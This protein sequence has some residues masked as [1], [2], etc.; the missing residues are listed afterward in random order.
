MGLCSETDEQ[1]RNNELNK[2]L[3][4]LYDEES[5]EIKLLL[6]GAGGSGKTTIFKQMKIIHAS[7]FTDKERLDYKHS[8]YKNVLDIFT[9]LIEAA[10]KWKIALEDNNKAF[11]S[12]LLSYRDTS[13]NFMLTPEMKDS[14]VSLWKDKSIQACYSRRNEIELLE[15]AKYFA[16]KVGE[17]CEKDYIPNVNDLLYCRTKT[18]GIV[19]QR[20]KG[21]GKEKRNLLFVDVGGQRNERRKWIHAFDGVTCVIFLVSIA[22]YNQV[23]EEDGKTNSL[24]EALTLFDDIC[25]DRFFKN[26]SVI[27]FYNKEDLFREKN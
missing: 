15:S 3:A 21:N 5:K 19:Q 6:L 7:G 2:Q 4:K 24:K 27:I 13:A 22:G 26:K 17:L 25:N 8:I 12:K 16:D 23:L 14:F 11:A 1:R 10:E 9:T 18:V 20:F